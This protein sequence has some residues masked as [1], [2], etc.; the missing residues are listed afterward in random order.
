MTIFRYALF[1]LILMS[2]LLRCKGRTGEAEGAH[3]GVTVG[4]GDSIELRA[5]KKL[6]VVG[7]FDG[8]GN[9][10]TIFQHTYSRR[11]SAEIDSAADPFQHEWE[12]V[13]KWFFDQ[14]ADVYL[15][16]KG[17]T[18]N[19]LHV[20][21]A[22]GLYCLINMG[23]INADGKD[24][25]AFVVDQLDF[26]LLNSCQIYSLC[27]NRWTLLKQFGVHEYA[28][29]YT[30]DQAPDFDSIEGYLE[31]ERGK[32]VYNDNSLEG[33]DSLQEAGKMLPLTLERCK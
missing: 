1:A 5:L 24:E 8:D 21:A 3:S 7:D 33:Y 20:G 4:T 11:V 15:T 27:N 13:V 18:R 14:D 30:S 9:R 12:V 28:F 6:F 10:D 16:F 22:Q 19:T 31:R 23:D 29:D 2:G 26:S 32:W 25:I 17:G